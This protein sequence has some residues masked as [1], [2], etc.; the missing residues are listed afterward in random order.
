[1]SVYD[2]ITCRHSERRYSD[3]HI[4]NE[5]I[6]KIIDAGLSAPSGQNE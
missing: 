3:Q 4:S 6:K 1:M 5:D 2:L